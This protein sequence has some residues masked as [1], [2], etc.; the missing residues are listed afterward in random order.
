[1]TRRKFTATTFTITPHWI[2]DELPPVHRANGA[3]VW[4]AIGRHADR[5]TDECWPSRETIAAQIGKSRATVE[6]A[7]DALE[8][9][10]A[11]ERCGQRKGKGGAWGSQQY[12]MH[13]DPPR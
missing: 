8:R 5:Y 4:V 7:I 11:L 2:M 3:A 6:R 1:V 13:Y 12:L 9:I 10:G